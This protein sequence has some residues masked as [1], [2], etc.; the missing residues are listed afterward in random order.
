M[1]HWQQE[2]TLPLHDALHKLRGGI[3]LLGIH[4]LE[5]R[6]RKQESH[7][8]SKGISRLETDLLALRR[9]LAQRTTKTEECPTDV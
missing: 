6:C 7:P 2:P 8:D 1:K 9:T 3:Q 5:V 4:E